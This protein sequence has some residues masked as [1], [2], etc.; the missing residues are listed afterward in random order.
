MVETGD[1]S[2][3]DQIAEAFHNRSRDFESDA[4]NCAY[5][6]DPQFIAVSKNAPSDVMDSFWKVSRNIIDHKLTDAQ[7]LPVRT[8]LATELQAFRMKTGPWAL[9]DYSMEDTVTFWGVAGCHAQLLKQI[10]FA[11]APLPCS[12]GEAE[13]SWHELKLNKTKT[14]NRLSTE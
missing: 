7:W 11:L 5:I 2:I 9:E 14:R 13:R 8:Q 6:I 3:E 4:A 1:D 10:A 12:S